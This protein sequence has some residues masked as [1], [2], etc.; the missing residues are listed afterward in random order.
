MNPSL[1]IDQYESNIF[2]HGHDEKNIWLFLVHLL[3]SLVTIFTRKKSLG[4]PVA[5]LKANQIWIRFCPRKKKKERKALFMWPYIWSL[6]LAFTCNTTLW[7]FLVERKIFFFGS[8]CSTFKSQP[9]LV[10]FPSSRHAATVVRVVAK[11][12]M[13]QWFAKAATTILHMNL[14]Q[15]LVNADSFYP[16][17]TN[18]IFQKEPRYMYLTQIPSLTH[19]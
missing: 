8:P 16:N 10:P 2:T 7:L 11:V 19:T 9:N 15:L 13:V 14:H 12:Y 17:F 4:H 1:N 6:I 3:Y 18:M 5:L